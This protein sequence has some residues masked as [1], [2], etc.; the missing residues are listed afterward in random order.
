M[1][2]EVRVPLLLRF[3]AV[4]ITSTL[5]YFL[6]A[7]S[8]NLI[9]AINPVVVNTSA[10]VVSVLVSYAGHHKFTYGLNGRHVSHFRRFV[11]VSVLL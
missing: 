6:V 7:A 9:A 3:A 1:R 11:T 8:L 5:I 10:V 4:G 2:R